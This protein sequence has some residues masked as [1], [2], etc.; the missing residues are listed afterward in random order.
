MS[1]SLKKYITAKYPTAQSQL[2]HIFIT[3]IEQVIWLQKFNTPYAFSI[4]LAIQ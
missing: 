2:K 3:A 4:N 1:P